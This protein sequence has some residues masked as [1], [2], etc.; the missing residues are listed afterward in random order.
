MRIR[1]G[2]FKGMLLKSPRGKKI[3]P[4]SARVKEAFFNIIGG[5]LENVNFLDLFS[6]TGSIGLEALSRG[7]ERAFFVEKDRLSLETLRKNIEFTGTQ[8][9][10]QIL[11]LEVRRAL[12]FLSKKRESFEIIFIDP[13]YDYQDVT[14]ILNY[15]HREGLVKEGGIIG[16]ERSG[17][18]RS[19]T[20]EMGLEKV[21]F[22]LWKKRIYG[23]TLLLIFKNEQISTPDGIKSKRR[24]LSG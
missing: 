10:A 14:K 5:Y 24:Y 4:T 16:V 21:P 22:Y 12:Q 13:P 8:A 2:K 19:Q 11:P 18:Q 23:N 6:G 3:R 7:A 15:L 9:R 20:G 1:A 17:L